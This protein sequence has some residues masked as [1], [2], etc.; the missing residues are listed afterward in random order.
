VI[1]KALRSLQHWAIELEIHQGVAVMYEH[2][3]AW[4]KVAFWGAG[5]FF[6]AATAAFVWKK[7]AKKGSAQQTW[8]INGDTL[9]KDTDERVV[10]IIEVRSKRSS[11]PT[12]AD[13]P[14][15]V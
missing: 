4:G 7:A 12:E 2:L 15:S 11:A 14:R 3:P 13:N 8:V 5:V 10:R 1:S 9:Y 6:M